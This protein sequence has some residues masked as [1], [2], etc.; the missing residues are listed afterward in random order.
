MLPPREK[1]PLPENVPR[2]GSNTQRCGQRAQALPTELF[3]P[4]PPP[5]HDLL[6]TVK[7]R[8]LK[9]CSHI[10]RSSG[11]AKA[12]PQG[13]RKRGRQRKRLENISE[14]TGLTPCEVVGTE[15]GQVQEAGPQLCGAPMVR[16]TA[17]MMMMMM[18][19]FQLQAHVLLLL[20][21]KHLKM[22]CHVSFLLLLSLK[23]L[24]MFCHVSFFFQNGSKGLL[25]VLA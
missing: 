7:K 19:T 15:E 25:P 3:R 17:G 4:P 8:N 5:P 13:S 2:G 14:S 22:F 1:S 18:M 23:H 16:E 9:W 20:S 11:L 21:L 12:F 24:K 6:T 10:S